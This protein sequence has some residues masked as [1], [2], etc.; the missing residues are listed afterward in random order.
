[1]RASKNARACR[2]ARNTRVR[3]TS[4]CRS[5]SSRRYPAARPAGVNGTGIT[6]AHR[7]KNDWM[8]AG[9]SRSQISCRPSGP[10]A[11]ANPP[12]AQ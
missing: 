7:S 9:P 8:P 10:P 5:D 12:A 2:G 4:T 1:M 11:E 3:D 6:A